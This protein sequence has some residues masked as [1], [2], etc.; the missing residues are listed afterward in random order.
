MSVYIH[1]VYLKSP[2]TQLHNE[3]GNTVEQT[4]NRKNDIRSLIIPFRVQIVRWH[5]AVD[6]SEAPALTVVARLR[7]HQVYVGLVRER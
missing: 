7:L 1:I 5:V 3:H 4:L 6:I 2:H